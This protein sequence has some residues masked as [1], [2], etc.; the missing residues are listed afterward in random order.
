MDH[1]SVY[2]IQLAQESPLPG[3]CVHGN[4]PLGSVIRG[5]FLD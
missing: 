5:K 2:W 3:S 4:E 1:E